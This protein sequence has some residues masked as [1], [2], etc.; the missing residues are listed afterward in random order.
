MKGKNNL[1]V[2]FFCLFLVS[3]WAWWHLCE[4]TS[5][6]I[7]LCHNDL[8]SSVHCQ[9]CLWASEEGRYH[10]HEVQRHQTAGKQ[11]SKSSQW[12]L[13]MVISTFVCSL[14]WGRE[15]LSLKLWPSKRSNGSC[16]P[17]WPC[18]LDF[19]LLQR[20]SGTRTTTSTLKLSLGTL[21]ACQSS[22]LCPVDWK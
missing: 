13:L 22:M 21:R 16:S 1:I 19:T 6:Q 17:T 5:W 9:G 3:G 12:Y 4:A 14:S 7:E 15:S 2:V 18:L 8:C 11:I 20:T 10:R